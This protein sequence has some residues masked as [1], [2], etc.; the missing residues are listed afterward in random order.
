MA[1]MY[2]YKFNINAEIYNVYRNEELQNEILNKVFSEIDSEMSYVYGFEEGENGK[3]VEYKFCDLLK[4]SDDLTVTGRLVKIYDGEVESYDRA[5]DTVKQI[6]EEDR[7]ASATFYF[8]LM[9]EEIGF[10]TRHG[11]GYIQFGEYFTKLLENRFPEGSFKLILEKNVGELRQKIYKMD[12]VLK[13]SC[14]MIPPNSNEKEFDNLLGATVEEF[15]ETGATKYTQG[16]E[17]PAKGK[18]TIKIK[19]KFFERIFYAVGKGYA[20]LNAEGRDK[21]N[22]KVTVNSDED[23]PY[24]LPVPEQEKDS[25]TAFREHGQNNVNKLLSDKALI[26]MK[27]VGDIDG[28]TE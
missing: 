27:S 4:S 7:A 15:K 12:R 10:I 18:N 8:D 14:T 21:N 22:E 28:E 3:I 24:K 23:T 6:Y 5:N 19:S 25:I 1:Q 17:I 20:D 9:K 26:K 2:F 16:M 11:L 13:V